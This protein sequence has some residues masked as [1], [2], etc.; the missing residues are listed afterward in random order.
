MIHRFSSTKLEQMRLGFLRI[1]EPGIVACGVAVQRRHPG[2][3][4]D[5]D[6]RDLRVWVGYYGDQRWWRL[7]CG[8][9]SEQSG[10][11]R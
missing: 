7:T 3:K 2:L 9:G 6:G 8:F 10:S 1:I 5:V 11:S 4:L